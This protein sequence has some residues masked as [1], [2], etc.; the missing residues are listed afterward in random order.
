[1]KDAEV[2][3]K[4]E[5]VKSLGSFVEIVSSDKISALVHQVIALAKDS[6]TIVRANASL[7]IKSMIP[8][9]SKD[10]A[11]QNIQPLIK[12]LMKDENQEVRKG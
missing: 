7:V 3:V 9:V 1:M 11:Y 2:D 12:D 10:Q 8:S 4:I 6:L 5:A